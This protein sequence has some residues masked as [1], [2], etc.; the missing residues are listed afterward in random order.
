MGQRSA[1]RPTDAIPSAIDHPRSIL[2][3][4]AL[5]CVVVCLASALLRVL[6]GRPLMPVLTYA[7]LAAI[8]V[9]WL[10]GQAILISGQD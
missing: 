9:I 7:S 3:V 4:A 5:L 6:S 1:D 10:V 8:E 2:N